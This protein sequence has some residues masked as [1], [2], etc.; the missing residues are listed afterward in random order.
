M[1]KSIL[2]WHK[3]PMMKRLLQ[4]EQITRTRAALDELYKLGIISICPG[5]RY[6]L[7][8]AAEREYKWWLL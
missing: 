3:D 8:P 7:T 6:K 2:N 5:G 1:S 4:Q